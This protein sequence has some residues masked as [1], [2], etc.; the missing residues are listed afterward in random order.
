VRPSWPGRLL[1]RRRVGR[2]APPHFALFTGTRSARCSRR[3]ESR[4]R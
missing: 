2:K 3:S 4:R 1:S